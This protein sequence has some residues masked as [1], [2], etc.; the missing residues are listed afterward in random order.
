MKI[1]RFN[2]D[3]IG[4]I[5]NG[6][7]MVVDVSDTVSARKAKGPQR[8]MEEIIEG[9]RKYRRRFEK[10]LAAQEGV[11]LSSVQ[12]RCPLPRPSK[13][14]AAFVNYIDRPD[15]SPDTLPNEYFYK[16][17]DL[18]GPGEMVELRDI[19]AA[20]VYQ[21]EAEF[22]FVIGKTAKDV[23]E[24]KAMD[25]VF[26]YVPFFDISTRG[27]A[28]RT[29]FIP[30]GQDTHGCCGPWVITK[31][32]I[33]DPDNVVVK[34]WTNGEARQNYNTQYMAHKIPDQI[35]W[36]TRFLRLNPGDVIATGTYHE[37]LRP[38]NSGDTI[39]IEFENLG[40][41]QFKVGGNSPRKDVDWLPG[42]SQP[43]PP[44]GGGM[45]RV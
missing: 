12:L 23:P 14:L 36:L 10:I 44:P 18:V 2:D 4:V 43:Q 39:E 38:M 11:P 16:S 9:W 32:E 40:K 13:C 41:A 45:H 33:P 42:K 8:V 27:L 34:S 30:K 35:A 15:R 3:R 6:N 17:P 20:V 1:L 25:Y 19:P 24:S 5:K 29:Q 31:D 7:N 22:A 37:G 21:P 28:R 26:G